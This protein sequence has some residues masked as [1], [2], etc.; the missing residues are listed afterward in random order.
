VLWDKS[1]H[2]TISLTS[3]YTSDKSEVHTKVKDLRWFLVS[4]HAAEGESLPP[5][6]GSLKLH[7]RRAHYIA[8]IWRRATESHPSL[9]SPAAYGWELLAEE[10]VYTPIRCAHPPAPEAVIN[11]VKCGCKKGCTGL[12]SCSKNNIPCTHPVEHLVAEEAEED[13]YE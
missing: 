5:T 10:G 13:D 3:V 2:F 1:P 11:L 8:M 12:C 7:I 4:N 9:P 6:T